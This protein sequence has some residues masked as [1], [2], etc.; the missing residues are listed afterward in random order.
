MS[1][2]GFEPGTSGFLRSPMKGYA[3]TNAFLIRPAL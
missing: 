1:L 2:P 3:L